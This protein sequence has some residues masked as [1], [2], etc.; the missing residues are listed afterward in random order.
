[1]GRNI[2]SGDQVGELGWHPV[3]S[4][5]SGRHHGCRPLGGSGC[6]RHAAHLRWPP[7][8]TC[9]GGSANWLPR[10]ACSGGGDK[11]LDLPE[12]SCGRL[13]YGDSPQIRLCEAVPDHLS[14][15]VQRVV[16]GPAIALAQ[17]FGLAFD[18]AFAQA[19][20]IALALPLAFAV[21]F[22]VV[23]TVPVTD[24]LRSMGARQSEN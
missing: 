23:F 11:R 12:A 24:G 20:E 3:P 19:I 13:G 2:L 14:T 10:H 8:R 17:D 5:S 7:R 16:L 9:P 22:T 15:L 6:E 21:A 18:I 1:M 4:R